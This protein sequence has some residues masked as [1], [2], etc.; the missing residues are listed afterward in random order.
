[1]RRNDARVNSTPPN[2]AAGPAAFHGDGTNAS[3]PGESLFAVLVRRWGWV[4][5]AFVASR[6]IIAFLTRLSRMIFYHGEF[7]QREGITGVLTQSD[8]QRYLQIAASGYAAG[9]EGLAHVGFFPLYPALIRV[10]SIVLEPPMAAMVISNIALIVAG[11]L[12]KE[13][14]D[15]LYNDRRITNAAVTFLMFSPLSFLF[16]GAYP[17]ATF[18]AL[19]LGAF[20]AA[21]RDRWLAAAVCGAAA[22]LASA[23]GW[24]IV[25]PLAVEYFRS[26]D[27]RESSDRAVRAGL[28]AIVPLACGAF[29]L[30]SYLRVG[31]ALAPFRAAP[32]LEGGAVAPWVT[33]GTSAWLPKFYRNFTLLMLTF[34]L[35]LFCAGLLLKV[36]ASH[37]LWAG[38]LL[39]AYT[40]SAGFASI[41]RELNVVFPFFIILAVL[42]RRFDWLYE[43]LLACTVTIFA[44]CTLMAANGHWMR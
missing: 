31:D 26:G 13:L 25:L 18:V 30:F 2:A 11:I 1:M 38:S 8:G 17:E 23:I 4:L 43:P 5:I 22:A 36:R 24:I 35:L 21:A 34:G 37:M 44:F 7:W 20:L 33:V 40:C 28:L 15:L 27:R 10:V 41:A 12:L 16:S 3:A 42:S 32:V 29:L 19:T 6:L 9:A 39:V 14:A